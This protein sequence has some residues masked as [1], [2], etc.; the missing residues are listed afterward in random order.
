MLLIFSLFLAL[1]HNATAVIIGP[2]VTY[3]VGNM[4][5]SV[6]R[7][8]N[9]YQIIVP[10]DNDTFIVFGNLNFTSE[11]GHANIVLSSLEGDNVSFNATGEAWLNITGLNN[12]Y[13]LHINGNEYYNLHETPPSIVQVESRLATVGQSFTLSILCH[14]TEPIK[15]WELK[16]KFNKS[17][18]S[19]NFVYEGDFFDGYSTFAIPGI[20]DNTN[21][22][23]IDIYNLILGQGNVSSSGILVNINFTAV[24]EGYAPIEIYDVGLCNETRYLLNTVN[25]G[26]VIV[27]AEPEEPPEELP[28]KPEPPPDEPHGGGSSLLLDEPP[29]NLPI[30]NPQDGDALLS[31]LIILFVLVMIVLTYL[32]YHL[33]K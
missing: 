3:R 33:H 23:I 28:I 32:G 10:L 30:Q 15:G 12:R 4:N 2:G 20:I 11:T 21:G 5:Y 1:Q 24:S 6:D 14:P 19:A 16:V 25:N 8:I 9:F 27:L 26:F 7:P 31:G 22:S 13:S 17:L 18:L 29:V